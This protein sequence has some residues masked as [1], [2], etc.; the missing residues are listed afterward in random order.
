MSV[1]ELHAATLGAVSIATLG[2]EDSLLGAYVCPPTRS[3][4]LSNYLLAYFR[5][6]VLG[7]IETKFRS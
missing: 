6:L 3:I 7:C 1:E 5:E 4:E 2:P